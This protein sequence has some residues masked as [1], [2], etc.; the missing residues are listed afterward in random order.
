MKVAQGAKAD[1][2]D[3]A[4]RVGEA[5]FARDQVGRRLGMR[6]E[7][8]RPG[9]AR[10]SMAVSPEMINGHDICHGGYILALADTAC[11]YACNSHN[12]NTLSQSLNIV[13]MAPAGRDV[14]LVAEA[15]ESAHSGRTSTYEIK[16]TNPGE[17][18]G[19]R[20]IAVAQAQ[21]R[22]VRGRMVESLPSLRDPDRA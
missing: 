21:C 3:I 22:T 18:K 1:A 4:A 14:T 5:M 15:M 10:V 12:Q 9:Y 17:Y 20:V 13:F 7:A 8:V 6:I 19:G 2:A 11:A 16:V